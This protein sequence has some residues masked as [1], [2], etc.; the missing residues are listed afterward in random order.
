MRR[1]F[2]LLLALCL[3][4]PGDPFQTFYVP[5]YQFNRIAGRPA[6]SGPPLLPG[7]D[8]PLVEYLQIISLAAGCDN[9]AVQSVGSASNENWIEESAY[10]Q[11]DSLA[12][13]LNLLIG[14]AI[15]ALQH[16]PSQVEN[17][18]RRVRI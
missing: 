16:L 7:T 5:G 8:N 6:Y 13:Y 10:R 11:K 12:R 4:C 14:D 15:P 18:S 17:I 9:P 3:L 2:L 1:V